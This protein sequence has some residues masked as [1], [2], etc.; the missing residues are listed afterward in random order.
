M[1]NAGPW[2]ADAMWTPDEADHDRPM[3][4]REHHF[5]VVATFFDDGTHKLSVDTTASLMN[6]DEPIWL[7]DEGSWSRVTDE[8]D[9][10]DQEAF[11]T[12]SEAVKNANER[13]S[14]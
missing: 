5:V 3:P 11:T 10:P 6:P 7:C 1:T 8:Y 4:V 12:L 14:R 13:T 2:M 9:G